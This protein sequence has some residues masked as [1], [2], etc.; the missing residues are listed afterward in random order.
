MLSKSWWY[1]LQFL[2][3]RAKQTEI[4]NFRS[5]FV[6][7]PPTNPKNQNFEKW[8]YLLEISSLYTCAPR[9]TSIWCMV[10]EIRTKNFLSFLVIF[11][12]FTSPLMIP[13]IKILKKMN[14]MAGDNIILY[15]HVYH[16]WR[17]YDV[18]FLKYKVQQTE[19]FDILGHFL[20]L[21]PPDKLENKN[22]NIEKRNLKILSFYTFAP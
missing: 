18:W 13:N 17:S 7:Y 8:K 15:I 3:Y 20:P 1:D 6:L 4:G 19:I 2:K 5:F 22:F 12:P 16:K 11:C 21:Q 14:K 9:I 10:P